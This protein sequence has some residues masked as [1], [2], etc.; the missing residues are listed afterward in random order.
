MDEAIVRSRAII[1][2]KDELVGTL[3]DIY[4]AKE[5]AK[6]VIIASGSSFNIA[7]S[8]KWYLQKYLKREVKVVWPMTYLHYDSAYDTDAFIICMSQSGKSTNT[9]E[10]VKKAKERGHDPIVLTTNADSPIR[11]YTEHV[12]AYGSGSDD[13]YVAKGYPCSN[14]FLFLFT[15]ECAKQSTLITAT[16]Y[17]QELQKL[18]DTIDKLSDVQEGAKAFFQMYQK[19]FI[20]AR[21]ILIVG[22]GSG[23]GTALEGA[24][25]MNEMIGSAT[26]AYEMEE[27]VHGPTYEIRKD[28]MVILVDQGGS[29]SPRMMQLFNALHKLCDHVF[30]ITNVKI[31]DDHI[32]FV[33]N[34]GDEDVNT[35]LNIIPFQ[36][37]SECICSSLDLL[38]YNL[39]NYDFEQEIKTKA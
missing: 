8:A 13:Y 1:Q 11:D 29:A 35:L 5:V 39:A 17:K 28:H 34:C 14:L 27:F 6:I 12:F 24:L 36:T 15:L 7:M 33:P 26:N 4:L 16:N 19:E 31:E 21:R 23:Y 10:A 20:H 18:K 2:D 22:I 3:V 38:S 37:F 32:L 25:K 9:I 30:M